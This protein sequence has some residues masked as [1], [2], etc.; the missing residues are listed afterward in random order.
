MKTTLI[1]FFLALLARIIFIF[2]Q[3]SS[4]EQYLIEDELMYWDNSLSFLRTGILNKDILYERMPSIFIYYKILL[5]LTSE[6]LKI[7]LYIQAVIDTISCF[8]FYRIA[9]LIAP[10]HKFFLYGFAALSP[11][12]II[13]SS[14]VLSETIFLFFFTFFIY[15]SVRVIMPEKNFFYLFIILSGLFLGISTSFRAITFPLIFLSLIPLTII[16]INKR[17]PKLKLMILLSIFL[18]SA[19]LPIS[20]RLINNIKMHNTFSLTSQ[21]GSHFAYWVVP[22][23]LSE[24]KGIKRPDALKIITD[25]RSK[26]LFTNNPYKNDV[27]LRNIGMTVLADVSLSKVIYAWSKGILINLSAPSIL[28]DK[29]LRSLPHPSY[30][31]VSN[32]I[33]WLQSLVSDKKY[34]NYLLIISLASITSI[35]SILSLIIG[36][37][38]LYRENKYVS[39]LCLLYVAYFMIITGPVLSPKYIFPILP[40]IFL[41]Q[42]FTLVK[43]KDTFAK[44]YW[45]IKNN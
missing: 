12:M 18:L 43:I 8:M 14:Q 30:Y 22:I 38:L 35:F 32:P 39:Y 1:F 2:F 34:Y 4:I 26:Y 24:S 17:I 23:I 45:Q 9:C 37:I 3:G 41:Y 15:F 19:L 44:Y 28:L 42:A 25:E 27:I 11:L 10:R 6:N 31:E 33:K 7:L 40:C 21:K 13:L 36:P 5:W 20:F 29:K 16:F